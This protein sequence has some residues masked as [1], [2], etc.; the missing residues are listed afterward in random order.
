MDQRQRLVSSMAQFCGMK[1]SRRQRRDDP[2]RRTSSFAR[3]WNIQFVTLWPHRSRRIWFFGST[4]CTSCPPLVLVIVISGLV[5]GFA[6]NTLQILRAS[7]SSLGVFYRL[8]TLI[9]AVFM[10][11]VPLIFFDSGWGGT[12]R[13]WVPLSIDGLACYF[14]SAVCGQLIDRYLLGLVADPVAR[15][16]CTFPVPNLASSTW[17][18]FAKGWGL[19]YDRM[20]D[21]LCNKLHH[22]G[23]LSS[24]LRLLP[25][26]FTEGPT[27][28]ENNSLSWQMGIPSP[29]C[30]PYCTL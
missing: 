2:H 12:S 7:I 23:I 25:P 6:P 22:R 14:L 24:G 3:Q 30:L 16:S 29:I 15:P 20:D 19:C 8:T 5:I 17:A 11:D 10:R 18:C 9:Y 4:W 27:R 21:F 1:K 26:P 13:D 28:L